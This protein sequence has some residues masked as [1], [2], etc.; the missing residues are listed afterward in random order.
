MCCS[1]EGGWW[2]LK[3]GRKKDSDHI[4]SLKTKDP[5]HLMSKRNLKGLYFYF[6]LESDKGR[7]NFHLRSLVLN[8]LCTLL[9]SVQ[10]TVLCSRT[11]YFC[12]V[13]FI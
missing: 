3:S 6:L 7:N 4:S 13:L 1:A 12:N 9:F 8:R 10:R 11:M 2:C 5:T